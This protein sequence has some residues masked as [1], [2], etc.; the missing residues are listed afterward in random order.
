MTLAQF[1]GFLEAVGREEKR[2]FA[3]ACASTRIGGADE[4]SY[5]NAMDKLETD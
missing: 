5:R 1:N 4:K 2:K 3:D